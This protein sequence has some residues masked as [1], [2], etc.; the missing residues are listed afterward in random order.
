MQNDMANW[1]AATTTT[2]VAEQSSPFDDRVLNDVLDEFR[3]T[4]FKVW[5]RTAIEICEG[6]LRAVFMECAYND[7]TGAHGPLKPTVFEHLQPTTYFEEIMILG[8]IVKAKCSSDRPQPLSG[9]TFVITHIKPYHDAQYQKYK[10]MKEMK[11][12]DKPTVEE[13]TEH[14]FNRLYEQHCSHADSVCHGI[15]FLIPEQGTILS[16]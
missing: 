3:E 14:Q 2:T 15:K 4:M 10:E 13:L 12:L 1:A 6:R 9:L 7:V 5:K 11:G 16:I 8:E